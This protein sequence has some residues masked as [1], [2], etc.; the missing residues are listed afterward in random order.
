MQK[1]TQEILELS[2]QVASLQG[3]VDSKNS[4]M[5]RLRSQNDSLNDKVRT[6][7]RDDAKLREK[8]RFLE[9][10][11]KE[12]IENHRY[13][14]DS[15]RREKNELEETYRKKFEDKSKEIEN[16][17]REQQEFMR[18]TAEDARKTAEKISSK[19]GGLSN[20]ANMA[21]M[22]SK[23]EQDRLKRQEAD[24]LER[25]REE[26]RRREQERKDRE[27]REKEDR[28][29]EKRAKEDRDRRD[30]EDRE[31]R[32]K[33]DRERREREDR[34][35]KERESED[36]ER[37]EKEE[38][39]RREEEELNRRY[40]LAQAQQTS[41]KRY[42][43]H[44]HS[45][46]HEAQAP[47]V[48]KTRGNVP[49]ESFV[50]RA[51]SHGQ[52]HEGMTK[53]ELLQLKAYEKY[54]EIQST[55]PEAYNANIPDDPGA[56]DFPFSHKSHQSSNSSINNDQ[57]AKLSKKARRRLLAQQAA[58]KDS[59]D[60]RHV[61]IRSE[62]SVFS[63]SS[64]HSGH[65]G[66]ND[67]PDDYHDK[68]AFE[69]W[70]NK[71]SGNQR[72]ASTHAK[73]ESPNDP[74]LSVRHSQETKPLAPAVES[75]EE[76]ERKR[77]EAEQRAEKERYQRQQREQRDK[78]E[79][80]KRQET[81]R[82]RNIERQ[83]RLAAKQRES[84]EDFVMQSKKFGEAN[85][86]YSHNLKKTKARV[87]YM[88]C[89]RSDPNRF[90]VAAGKIVYVYDITQK[91]KP[92][93]EI[94]FAKV[95]NQ[96]CLTFNEKHIFAGGKGD[97]VYRKNIADGSMV[98]K[99]K[100]ESKKVH[101]KEINTVE[102]D[103]D[104]IFCG[105]RADYC[106]GWDLHADPDSGPVKKFKHAAN[107]TAI[108]INGNHLF[109]GGT[110][111]RTIMW[112]IPKHERVRIFRG[113]QKIV[114]LCVVGGGNNLFTAGEDGNVSEWSVRSGAKLKQFDLGSQCNCETLIVS[115]CKSHMI[116]AQPSAI[117]ILNLS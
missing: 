65:S 40:E 55:N 109:T 54:H 12:E 75:P 10:A 103:D 81:L 27:R 88:I 1:Q 112:N 3:Q 84:S 15:L 101:M 22:E 111:G 64:V 94:K 2:K 91:D 37:R 16:L 102:C 90:Y 83:E 113:L 82:I 69:K 115:R 60:D 46:S 89:S 4:E 9:E 63:A 68:A 116:S 44:A 92:I 106:F 6:L 78:Q 76:R 80:L 66:Q 56:E 34:E 33:L 95:I 24:D 67:E 86:E 85:I 13:E 108:C 42:P 18:K 14:K 99:Y 71:Q 26:D 100:A 47:V 97:F 105:G 5:E 8:A 51:R 45:S 110:R 29:R 19:I 25:R 57:P 49:G 79:E 39:D 28:E 17:I 74:S 38:R 62:A 48:N 73:A 59:G 70:R 96:M 58:K 107:V 52:Y 30:R 87:K 53:Y 117:E 11:K 114:N 72:Q 77:I 98:T 36:R 50:D 93:R 41:H 23:Y 32:D 35:R 20:V 61:T 43:D 31:R 104:Y 21:N 7:T